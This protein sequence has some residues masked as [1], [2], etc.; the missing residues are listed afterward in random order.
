M[1]NHREVPMLSDDRAREGVGESRNR[2]EQE[3]WR[4]QELMRAGVV[5]SKSR[6]QRNNWSED[7]EEEEAGVS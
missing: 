2:R 5:E 3:S 7:D 4:E 6:R 1:R